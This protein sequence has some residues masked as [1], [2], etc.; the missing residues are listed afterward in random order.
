M[1]VIAA[2]LRELIA[3]GI[4]GDE[5]IDAVERI[6]DAQTEDGPELTK[7]QER[8]A[9]YYQ[10][11]KGR[12]VTEWALLRE[13][14]F[15]ER[16]MVCTYC[17]TADATEI[18]HIVPLARGGTDEFENLAPACKPCNCS[19]KDFLLSEWRR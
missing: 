4:E 6:E 17:G 9:R 12:R 18:D 5:L 10:R 19:K 8:N 14:V 7:R 2:V 11:S 16:G 13:R 1:G 15:A 3:A